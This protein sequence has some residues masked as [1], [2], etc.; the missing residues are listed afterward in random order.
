METLSGGDPLADFDTL[1]DSPPTVTS[2]SQSERLRLVEACHTRCEWLCRQPDPLTQ[3]EA[4]RRCRQYSFAG[5][6]MAEVYQRKLEIPSLEELLALLSVARP[7]CYNSPVSQGPLKL[8]RAWIQDHRWTRPLANALRAYT[9]HLDGHTCG[10]CRDA[11]LDLNLF[12]WLDEWEPIDPK[13]SWGNWLRAEY[14]SLP[15]KE[16]RLWQRLFSGFQARLP[17]GHPSKTWFKRMRKHIDAIGAD[18][19][20]ERLCAWLAPLGSREPPRVK[21]LGSNLLRNLLWCST[22]HPSAALDAPVAAIAAV[23]WKKK[24]G[25]DKVWPAVR[26]YAAERPRAARFRIAS[27]HSTG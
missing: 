15:E 8:V 22:L 19:F 27:G 12:L 23:K 21:P 4:D 18:R 13:A 14:R 16:R 5:S 20:T 10:S 25:M 17:A 6:L 7:I 24:T 9:G 2:L 11:R 3:E 26:A 1:E